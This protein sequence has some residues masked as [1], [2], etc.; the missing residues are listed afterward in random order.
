MK[1]ENL[2]IQSV[3]LSEDY[4]KGVVNKEYKRLVKTFT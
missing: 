4:A 2:E 1:Q 3:K